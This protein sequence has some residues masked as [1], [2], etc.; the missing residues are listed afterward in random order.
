MLGTILSR[1]ALPVLVVAIALGLKLSLANYLEESTPFL[2]FLAPIMISG[3]LGGFAG[4]MLATV[5]ATLACD[6]FFI[7]PGQILLGNTFNQNL[8]LLLFL[9]E[10]TTV[11]LIS[12]SLRVSQTSSY[13]QKQ[14]LRENEEKF[15]LLLEGVKDY[16]IYMLDVQGRVISWNLGAERIEGYREEEILNSNFSVFYPPEEISKGTP[17]RALQVAKTEGHYEWEGWQVRRDKSRFWAHVIVN[18]LKDERG[19]LRGY[20]K[21]ARD[22]SERKQAEEA[23]RESEERFRTMA[24]TAPVLIWRAEPNRRYNYFNK[25]WLDFTGR[26]LEQEQGEGWME[27]I[28]PTDRQVFQSA[29]A[30][31]F[32]ERQ[33]F[34][35][36]YRLRRRLGDYRWILNTGV[37]TWTPSGTFTGYV[38]TSLD[39]TELKQSGEE[40]ERFT[41]ELAD[42]RGR[43]EAVLR[44][45][46]A[47]LLIVEAP[48]G[49]IILTNDQMNQIWRHSSDPLVRLQHE[50][51]YKGFYA[52][53]RA[54]RPEDWPHMRSINYGEVVTEEEIDYERGDGTRSTMLVSSSPVR[55]QNGNIMAAVAT[56][57]DISDRKAAE[58]ERAQFL[59]RERMARK[60][61][62]AAN[63]TKD[64][65]LATLSHELRTPLTSILGWV[66]MMRTGKLDETNFMRAL[67]T[68]QRSAQSQAHL[69]DELLD[70]SRVVTGKLRLEVQPMELAP[71]IEEAVNAIRPAAEAKGINMQLM[72]DGRAGQVSCDQ[73]RL[74][75]VFWNLLSNAVKFT[76][77]DGHI[78][79]RLRREGQNVEVSVSDTGL[80]IRKDFLPHV[81]ERFRQG[82]SSN[83]RAH[84]GLGLGLAIVRH[85]VELHGGTVEVESRGE[86]HG[87]TFKVTLPVVVQPPAKVNPGERLPKLD[88]R[89]RLS[90]SSAGG[91]SGPLD[92]SV[93]LNNLLMLDGVRVLVV[94]DEAETLDLLSAVLKKYGAQVT[95]ATSAADAL[96]KMKSSRQDVLVSDIQMP[97]EN[98]YDLIGK[99]RALGANQGG[100]VPAAAL[101]AYA[102][103]EDRMRAL[104]AGFQIHVPKPVEPA[105]LAAVV[106]TLAGR[107]GKMQ[108]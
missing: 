38:G 78:A 53:G 16:A 82:D 37:P 2:L 20:A 4:G 18:A 91:S 3:W 105:E 100:G 67:E 24:D 80:G 13:K 104:L 83:T 33:S 15:R 54:Y 85:L 41:R 103:V 26:T 10:G 73:N 108:D 22:I 47:G 52:N 1:V 48:G 76:P 43:L 66:R 39:I 19:H 12:S 84:G 87:A 50:Q 17:E 94:D 90:N 98:G 70:V 30:Q 99:V 7:S 102:G 35:V 106:A 55:D 21:S 101:T 72:L 86:G 14:S 58:R 60:E 59:A 56:F 8:P 11:S 62:E 23:L 9:L 64:E 40:R 61:A 57:Y 28:H 81:F 49:K 68:I 31:A 25:G 69:I 6:Y 107:N 34:K 75:Q 36:E 44:Q 88:V 51:E 5:L 65:F 63:R 46:P 71:I 96:E 93:S 42:Q 45:M 29:Y 77:K 27:G 89:P 92:Q 32:D 79:I 95:P 97:G 74:H